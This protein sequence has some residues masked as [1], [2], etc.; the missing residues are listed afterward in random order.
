MQSWLNQA[1]LK[2]CEEAVYGDEGPSWPETIGA[3]FW[4]E[5]KRWKTVTKKTLYTKD[6]DRFDMEFGDYVESWRQS[7][8]HDFIKRLIGNIVHSRKKVPCLVFDNTDH[9]SIEFQE[10]VFQYARSIYEAELSMVLMPI[11]DRTSWQL[12]KQGVLQSFESE[13]FHL[14]VP[15]PFRVVE[16]RIHYLAGKVS[17]AKIKE[18]ADYFIGR[19]IRLSISDIEK[20][21]HTLNRVFVESKATSE[22]MGSLVNFDVRR[23]LELV[24]DVV[25]SPHLSIDKLFV[26][27]VAND[28]DVIPSWKVKHAIIKRKYDIYPTAEHQ[29]VQNIFELGCDPPSSPLLPLRLLQFLRDVP[30]DS[31]NDKAAFVPLVDVFEYFSSMGFEGRDVGAAIDK[32]LGTG[33]VL[34]YDPTVTDLEKVSK[35]EIAPAGAIHL[36]WGT[37][38]EDYI[39]IMAQVTPVRDEGVFNKLDGFS[40]NLSVNWANALITF[41][42]YLIDEDSHWCRIPDHRNYNGQKRV[43]WRLSRVADDARRVSDSKKTFTRFNSRYI[44]PRK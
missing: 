1:F 43:T 26:A 21:A 42:D 29:F 3:M 38:D 15:D 44:E 8:P 24:K 9:H 34:N 12:S 19:N 11:T 41:V 13:I 33:L 25:G 2:S 30:P 37:T 39:K 31:V 6:R 5:Y 28:A 7:E 36:L 4:R 10:A 16:R 35:I 40:R 22:W 23:L 14:P 32:L 17:E 27:H 18:S 20:F